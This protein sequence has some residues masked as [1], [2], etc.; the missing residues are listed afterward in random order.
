MNDVTKIQDQHTAGPQAIGFDYQF[1]FFM[2]LALELKLGQKVGFEVKD[3]VHIDKEDGTTILYQAKHTVLKKADGSTDNLTTLDS[4]L[5][6]TLS[7]WTDMV[8]SNPTILDN[9]L[10]CLVTNKSKGNNKFIDAL[11][12]FKKDNDID[13]VI[14]ILKGLKNLTTDAE[15]KSFIKNVLS[16]GKSKTKLFLSKL[17]IETKTD[18]IIGKVKIKILECVKNENLVDAV[19]DSLLSNLSIA[20]YMDIKDRRKFEISFTE[21]NKRF[22][23]CFRVA[24]KD[25][26]LPK[27]QF[28]FTLPEKLE[29]QTFIKQLLDI[30]E[31]DKNSS[32]IIDYTTQ[33]LQ[34]VN[35]LSYWTENNFILPTEMD[36]FNKTSII[37]WENEFRAKYRQI[38]RQINS[39]IS[40]NDLE[41]DIQNLA[42][43]LIDFMRRQNLPVAGDPL[44]IEL[45]N[46]HYYALSN[47]PE[48]GW[49]F[50]WKQKYKTDER[51]LLHIQ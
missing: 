33:M 2:C 50:G 1:Y 46:G 13:K 30:G 32:K 39:G 44:G 40:I 10:F 7:N 21:F 31:L 6:K 38:E 19:F 51:D 5:W 42:L 25:K 24:F 49:H 15:L 22:G 43:E 37:V 29:E 36:E 34:V 11:T 41:S 47:K 35:H 8:K 14:E 9:H 28:T 26:P 16:L 45:S 4:D 23:K 12:L 20:K 17:S 27:R 48:I 18:D 3:D